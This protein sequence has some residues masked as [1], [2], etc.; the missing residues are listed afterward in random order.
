M[1]SRA[2]PDSVT[3]GLREDG[4]H[5]CGRGHHGCG[6]TLG[7]RETDNDADHTA[8]EQRGAYFSHRCQPTA[9]AAVLIGKRA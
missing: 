2:G 4:A 3:K 7:K 5:H 6:W 9:C 1:G 8:Y